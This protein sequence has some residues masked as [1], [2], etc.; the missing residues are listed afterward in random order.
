MLFGRLR[1]DRP[2]TWQTGI[3]YDW[4]AWKWRIRLTM[5]AVDVPEIS[6]KFQMG[7]SRRVQPEQVHSGY[8]G[9]TSERFTFSDAAI[10]LLT[11]GIKWMGYLPERDVLWNLGVYTNWLS[12]RESFSYYERQVVGRLAY[13]R[14]PSD[15]AGTL[16]HV[17]AGVHIGKPQHD[18]LQ[19]KSKPEVFESPNFIDT[20]E[21]PATQGTIAGLEVYYRDGPWLYGTEYYVEK[22]KSTQAGN[23]GFQGGDVFVSW[24]ITGETRPYIAPLGTFGPISPADR[25]GRAARGALEAVLR[26]SYIDLDTDSLSGGKFWRVTPM[27][28]W[29]LNDNARLEVD[30]GVGGLQRFGGHSTT[31]FF[32]ARLQLQF[33]KLSCHRLRGIVSA[34]RA[35][36]QRNPEVED[37]SDAPPVCLYPIIPAIGMFVA[38]L[39]F[40]EVGRRLGVRRLNVPGARAGVGV[41]DGSVYALVALLIGFT[42]NGAASRFDAR[43]ELVGETANVAGT[44]WQRIDMLPPELQPPVRDGDAALSR[45]A[46]LLVRE[47]D[48][49]RHVR[50]A[51]PR[52]SRA[53]RTTCGRRRWRPACR[54]RARRRAC[55]S[56][57]A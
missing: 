45:C 48:D 21:F 6:S 28:N 49:R 31:E 54:R 15:T 47:P 8:D 25:C 34:H 22:A 30:Y 5:I 14:M 24:I 23:P 11:D 26:V 32:Q 53:R 35:A 43:R 55:C 9:W 57:R 4:A 50:C 40:L 1:T 17:G 7:A 56:C 41:V 52:R 33:S 42:F 12:E 3:M 18:T 44:A 10:P 19:L 2:I 36:R 27:V 37:T 16:W 38:I 29:Y 39:V 13:L 51:C 46:H 20:G